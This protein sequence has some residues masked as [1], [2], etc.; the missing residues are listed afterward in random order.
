MADEETGDEVV[1]EGDINDALDISDAPDIAIGRVSD[2]LAA[3]RQV[4]DAP[5]PDTQFGDFEG[6]QL[7]DVST[8]QP[9]LWDNPSRRLALISLD[10]IT[11][12]ETTSRLQRQALETTRLMRDAYWTREVLEL[13]DRALE[14]LEDVIRRIKREV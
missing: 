1:G 6:G 11:A 14:K 8:G 3:D 13:E 7:D 12:M 2:R 5:G 10:E 4:G 9:D